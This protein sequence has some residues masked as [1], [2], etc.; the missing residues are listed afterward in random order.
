MSQFEKYHPILTEHYAFDWLTK[1]RAIDVFHLYEEM[2]DQPITMPATATK[3][4]QT[5]REIF[6][7]QKL[8]WGVTDRI[9]GHFVGQA[10]FDPIDLANKEATISVT[11]TPDNAQDHVLHELY[12]RLVTFGLAELKLTTLTV[13]LEQPD[14]QCEQILTDLGFQL[15]TTRTYRYQK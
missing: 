6:R 5:M 10:G 8:V 1:A 7:D 9:N 15:T 2:A 14:H 4:N 12:Q 13:H 3:I 11:V